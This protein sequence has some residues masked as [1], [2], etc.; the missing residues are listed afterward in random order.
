MRTSGVAPA[1]NLIYF[2]VFLFGRR[3]GTSEDTFELLEVLSRQ[4]ATTTI[5]TWS[6]PSTQCSVGR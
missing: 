2:P 1:K 4:E 6:M 3:I 5:I